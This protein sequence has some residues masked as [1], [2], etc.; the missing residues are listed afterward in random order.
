MR[1]EE[2]SDTFD[3]SNGT[4]YGV[5]IV[6]TCKCGQLADRRIRSEERFATL[7]QELLRERIFDTAGI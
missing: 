4:R 5:E 1:Q 6:A 3:D 7:P 2:L